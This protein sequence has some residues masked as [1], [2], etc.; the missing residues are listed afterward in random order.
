[1]WGRLQRLEQRAR[2]RLIR[3]PQQDGSVAEFPRSAVADAFVTNV[4][5]LRGEGVDPHPLSVAAANSSDPAWRDNFVAGE[6]I[7][8]NERGDV[9]GPPPDLSESL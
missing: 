5:R 9:L 6:G 1:M 3:I 7:I 4:A 2:G 8:V